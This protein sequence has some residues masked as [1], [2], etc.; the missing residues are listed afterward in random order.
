MALYF[1]QTSIAW[2]AF[3]G[4]Y[5]LLLRREKM[6]VGNRWYLLGTLA[7][8]LVLPLLSWPRLGAP[9]PAVLSGLSYWL[10]PVVVTGSGAPSLLAPGGV[11]VWWLVYVAG[12]VLA[13]G[14]LA[15]GLWRIGRLVVRHPVL[16]SDGMR[17]VQV[18]GLSLPFSWGPYLFC[19]PQPTLT[20]V[21]HRAILAHERAH[22]RQGHSWDVLA[23][24]LIG[25]GFWWNPLW[26]LYRRH[27]R[28]LHEYLADRAVTRHMST[29][30]YG[31]LLIRQALQGGTPTLTHAFHSSKIKTRILMLTKSNARLHAAWRYLLVLPLFALVLLAC[32]AVKQGDL[33]AMP[34]TDYTYQVRQV[35]TII[36][37]DPATYQQTTQVIAMKVYQKAE[38]MPVFGS[39]PNLEGD[40]LHA[41][42]DNNLLSY[43]FS[44]IKYPAAAHDLGLQ[45]MAVGK[46]YIRPDG[47]ASDAKIVKGIFSDASPAP[48]PAHA[49]AAREME[50]EVLKVL[51]SLPVW[52]PGKIN[53][54][55]VVVELNIPIKF[56]L[57]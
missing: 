25:I 5:Q 55:P 4:L 21:E 9:A 2:L 28:N 29:R 8:G 1:L 34:T 57:E 41:C 27:I 7:L 22:I 39:C 11:S 42:S 49:S 12:C 26:Y 31:Q 53:N 48:T 35:D 32:E 52:Q 36:T 20:P 15:Y 14:R 19:N 44:Q 16:H 23:L 24:E 10:Q 47:K 18:P 6:L 13:A 56:A 3:L 54:E 33:D 45:G 51:R 17:Q 40:A 38:E 50:E 46:I 30:T 37:F 43:I